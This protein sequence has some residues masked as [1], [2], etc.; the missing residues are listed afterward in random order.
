M[1]NLT[2]ELLFFYLVGVYLGLRGTFL[3]FV[4]GEFPLFGLVFQYQE[5][6]AGKLSRI[7]KIFLCIRSM[8]IFG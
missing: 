6:W 3:V 8:Y 2:L 5:M 1:Q 4:F 7:E